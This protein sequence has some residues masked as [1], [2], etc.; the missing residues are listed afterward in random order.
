LRPGG[1]LLISVPY[2]SPLRRAVSRIKT[3]DRRRVAAAGLDSPTEKAGRQFFQYAYTT[4][5]FK[6]LLSSAGF[7]VIATQGYSIIWGL[8]ELPLVEQ[9]MVRLRQQWHGGNDLVPATPTG[10]EP[11]AANGGMA[12][13]SLLKRLVIAEDASVPVAGG[14]VRALRWLCA[15]MMMYVCVRET[16]PEKV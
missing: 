14:M 9:A 5:Q 7:R 11:A 8:Y 4:G 10:S 6:R 13:P 1:R 12:R 15:N 16:R 3:N 2:F